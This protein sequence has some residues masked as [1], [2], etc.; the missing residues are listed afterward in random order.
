MFSILVIINRRANARCKN[1]VELPACES[2]QLTVCGLKLSKV[3]DT[4]GTH[5]GTGPH[6]KEEQ[7]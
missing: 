4:T 1:I 5:S 2:H 7:P 3:P 6:R